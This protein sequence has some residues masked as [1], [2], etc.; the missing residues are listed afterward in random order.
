MTVIWACVCVAIAL[1]AS[2]FFGFYIST[3]LDLREFELEKKYRRR[4]SVCVAGAA[5]AV[6]LTRDLHEWSDQYHEQ[7]LT[8][9][10]FALDEPFRFPSPETVLITF[11]PS[12]ELLR[13]VLAGCLIEWVDF[14]IP[15][16]VPSLIG[17]QIRSP[18]DLWIAIHET[19]PSEE[20]RELLMA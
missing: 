10:D 8:Q 5:Y 14:I 6:V 11:I 19:E 13:T 16:E 18:L 1:G 12:N 4:V 9:A 2:F 3:W 20:L 15:K 17:T 7:W